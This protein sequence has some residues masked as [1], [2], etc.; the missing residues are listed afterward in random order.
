MAGPVNIE[1]NGCESV[2]H[3]HDRDLLVTKVRCKD[4]PR[5]TSDVG[6]LST[7]LVVLWYW[8]VTERWT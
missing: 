1:L 3:D 6:I 2:V 8:T 7:H 5:V 4:Q